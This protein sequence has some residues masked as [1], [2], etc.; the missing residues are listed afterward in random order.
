[1]LDYVMAAMILGAAIIYALMPHKA[2]RGRAP[3]APVE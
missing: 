1:V 3:A 2:L